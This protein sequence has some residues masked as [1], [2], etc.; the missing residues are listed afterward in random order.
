MSD[1]HHLPRL[2]HSTTG[3]YGAERGHLALVHR[4]KSLL[5]K[6]GPDSQRRL[7]LSRRRS[8][9]RGMKERR[10]GVLRTDFC[11]PFHLALAVIAVRGGLGG[12]KR[13][14]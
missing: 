8:Q 6:L 3:E 5:L 10:R 1:N 11:G 14:D 13:A 7:E 9:A 4:R 2:V 12:R